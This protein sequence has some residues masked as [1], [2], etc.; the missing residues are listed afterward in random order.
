MLPKSFDEA[1]NGSAADRLYSRLV[2]GTDL[3]SLPPLEFLVD[4]LIPRPS[5]GIVYAPPKTYK[6]FLMI[7][8]AMHVATGRTWCDRQVQAAPVLYVIGEGASGMVARQRA[9]LDYHGVVDADIYWHPHRLDL[10]QLETADALGQVAKQLGV[11]LVVIDTVARAMGGGADESATRDMAQ[12]VESLDVIKDAAGCA[13]AGVHHSGKDKTKGMRGSSALLGAVDWV[14]AVSGGDGR[15]RMELEDARNVPSG[16]SWT[17]STEPVGE[18]LVL[19]PGGGGDLR[20]VHAKAMDLL[21]V[22]RD[23]AGP[24][25]LS[26]SSWMAVAEMPPSTFFRLRKSLIDRCLVTNVGTPKQPRYAVGVAAP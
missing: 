1:V 3:A 7:D 5:V 15:L 6:T 25:G 13:V 16:D 9:W 12:F 20:Q 21:D 11:G 23:T 19:V 18:S 8:V 10:M 24:E 26:A 4:R 22:L 2:R 14:V 17:F